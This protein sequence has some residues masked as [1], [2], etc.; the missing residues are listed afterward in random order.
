VLTEAECDAFDRADPLRR[1]R[2]Q[3][4]YPTAGT[5]VGDDLV[6]LSGHSLGLM[7]LAAR[8]D[9]TTV[10]DA[11]ALLGVEGHFDGADPWYRYDEALAP[12][13]AMLVGAEAGEV[14]LMG[15]LTANLH[16]LFASFFQPSGR[17]TKILI[18][19]T[20]FP[21]DRYAVA[22]QL[23]WHGLDPHEHLIEVSP[24]AAGLYDVEQFCDVMSSRGDEIAL[25]W[26]GAVNYLTGE[27]LDV[28][29]VVE[30]SHCAGCVVGFDLAHA[31]GNIE[32]Q[33]HRWDVDFA[34]WC[35]Y[36]YLNGGPGAVAGL[37]VHERH[38]SD[39][40]RLRLAGWWGND[41]A[42][43]FE[44]ASDFV[45]FAGAAGWRMSNPPI[46]SLAPLKASLALFAAAGVQ[47]LRTK[48]LA[49]ADHVIERLSTM[50][51]IEVLTP[52]DPQ[53]RGSQV[54]ISVPGEA[55][56]LER[57][58][59]ARGIV[60]DVRPPDVIR[61][62]AAPLYNSARDVWYLTETLQSLYD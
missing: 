1:F 42:T 38:G 49:L 7:P 46:L 29:R 43:R 52:R 26:L 19:A 14:A 20:A 58:L 15:T 31:A 10:L 60:V 27:A 18:E 34:A 32:L 25:V 62:A 44:M 53:R 24:D 9:V 21:S 57:E 13:M 16:H 61:L 50:R 47:R 6:Y 36:K 55:V 59:R 22:A 37:F 23:R 5:A 56:S 30:A 3:F 40:R 35:T 33:L 11:W 48:S 4:A 54:S 41:P 45:P 51:S 8:D 12:A 28:S 17:R 39:P 2:E